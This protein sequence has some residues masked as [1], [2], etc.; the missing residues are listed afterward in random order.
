[1]KPPI[2]HGREAPQRDQSDLEYAIKAAFAHGT[3][4]LDGVGLNITALVRRIQENVEA[5][6]AWDGRA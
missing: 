2:P 5:L 3:Y 4:V 1:M 6:E